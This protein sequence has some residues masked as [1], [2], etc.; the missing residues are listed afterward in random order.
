MISSGEHSYDRI[1]YWSEI[2]LDIIREYAAA[3]SKILSAQQKPSLRHIYVDAF[4]GAGLHKSKT[5]GEFVAG[6]PTN[7][8]HVEPRF[9]EYHFIDLDQQKVAALETLATQGKDVHVYHGDCNQIL[10]DE[11][12]PRAQWTDYRRALCIL[13]PYG[14]HLNW[15]V[16]AEAGRMRSVEVFLNFPVADINRNVLWRDRQQVANTQIERMNAYWGD[17]SWKNVAYKPSRQTE[18]WGSPAEEK[19]T[20]EEVAEAFRRRLREV[21]G[22]SNV[23]SPIAMRNTQNAVV[24]YLFFASQKP[25]AADIVRAIF[26]KYRNHGG[27]SGAVVD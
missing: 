15:N 2:K 25:V 27:S 18:L 22:F 8:L 3:Y 24:Y 1:G 10:L 26:H 21:A 5:S 23:P 4:A 17:D 11:V 19:A 9:R 6:S 12:F 7:A 16:I 20:N 14:L 13:D